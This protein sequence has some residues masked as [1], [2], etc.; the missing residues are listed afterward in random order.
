MRLTAPIRPRLQRTGHSPIALVCAVQFYGMLL[1]IFLAATTSAQTYKV[2]AQNTTSPYNGV[3]Q[4][5]DGNL[6][7]TTNG[8]AGTYGHGGAVTKIT[9]AGKITTVYQFCSLPNCADGLDV[10]GIVMGKDGNIYGVTE[11]GGANS[12]IDCSGEYVQTCGT[13]FKLTT[14]GTLTTLYNFCSQTNCTDGSLPG[15][16]LIQGTDGNFYGLTGRGGNSPGCPNDGVQ[17]L[18]CGTLFS[19]TPTGTLTTVY[20]FCSQGDCS[21]GAFPSGSVVQGR[22]GNFYG[23]ALYGGTGFGGVQCGSQGLGCGTI[24]EVTPEGALTTLYNFCIPTDCTDG[25]HPGTGLVL[26]TNGIFY[27]TAGGGQYNDG[28][29]FSFTPTNVYTNLYS[30]CAVS[31]CPD[32]YGVQGIIQASDGNF[33]GTTSFDGANDGGTLFNITPAGAFTTLYSFCAQTNCDDGIGPTSPLFQATNGQIYG[34][35]GGGD[36]DNGVLFSWSAPTLRRFVETLPASGKVGSKVTIL[37]NGL[38]G[39]TAV[40]FNGTA[41]TYT[42]VSASEITA[43]VPTGATTGKVR[44]TTSTGAVVSSVGSFRIP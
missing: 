39:A 32:G 38:T 44:V 30:F 19:I 31:S 11:L 12:S 13:V 1:L 9:P 28:T 4:G 22:N 27:G 8:T 14:S 18:G 7:G 15:A 3:V 25:A 33:Y 10:G 40:S 42:V 6:Y 34:Y 5:F 36:T 17:P 26:A 16:A 24:F 35:A 37:G 43:T 2:V 23:T 41:A 20:S 29:I 21:D